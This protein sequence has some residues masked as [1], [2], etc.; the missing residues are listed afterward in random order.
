MSTQSTDALKIAL[1]AYCL[2]Y[3]AESDGRTLAA[4]LSNR[5]Y[6][7]NAPLTPTFPYATFALKTP[8][9]DDGLSQLKTSYDFEGFIYHRPT[10]QRAAAETLADLWAEA[11]RLYRD[12]TSGLAYATDVVAETLPPAPSPADVNIVTVRV[13]AKLRVWPQ[14][15]STLSS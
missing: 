13:T 1:R 15:I 5:L 11:L 6:R 14:F 8:Q 10:A 9:L 3:A 2:A 12:A 7:D 4:G